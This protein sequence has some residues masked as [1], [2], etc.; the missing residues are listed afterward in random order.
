ML[1]LQKSRTVFIF[2]KGD[3]IIYTGQREDRYIVETLEPQAD[4]SYFSLEF[5]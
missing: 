1:W 4:D 3:Y 2:L 5:F